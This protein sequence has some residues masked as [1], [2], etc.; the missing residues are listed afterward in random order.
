M[1]GYV[2]KQLA[3]WREKANLRWEH[4]KHTYPKDPDP[5]KNIHAD[6][7][8]AYLK[9]TCPRCDQEN[10]FVCFGDGH[11]HMSREPICTNCNEQMEY[12]LEDIREAARFGP[13]PEEAPKKA[14]VQRETPPPPEEAIL[15]VIDVS[16]EPVPSS[17]TAG[18][19]EG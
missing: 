11:A 12:L 16:N 8:F 6:V 9:G 18:L 10:T 15:E 3:E 14:K 2:E 13:P 7:T 5:K 1:P 19:P 17:D 4:V